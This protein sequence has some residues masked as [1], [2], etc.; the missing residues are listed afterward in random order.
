VPLQR[1]GSVNGHEGLARQ[2]APPGGR[3][4]QHDNAFLGLEDFRRAQRW[5]ARLVSVPWVARLDR[6]AGRVNPLLRDL[7]GSRPSSW[8][9]PQAEYAPDLV[10][11]SRAPVADFGPRLLDHSTLCFS[12]RDV[13]SFLGRKWHGKFEGE[14][15]TDQEAYSLRGR[16]PGGRGK[17]RRKRN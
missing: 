7:L 11:K 15:G 9:T 1:P 16:L 12:A 4:P 3:Y 14:V 8:V 17:H 10:V 5:S 2:L 6:Y 13:L